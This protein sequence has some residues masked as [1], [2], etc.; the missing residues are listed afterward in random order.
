MRSVSGEGAFI[1]LPSTPSV[2]LN[3][4]RAMARFISSK[5]EWHLLTTEHHDPPPGG[6]H[7]ATSDL[8]TQAQLDH[9]HWALGFPC[10][11]IQPSAPAVRKGAF[12]VQKVTTYAAQ[13]AMPNR[14]PHNVTVV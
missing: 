10:C 4:P 2:W 5:G 14:V 3:T 1:D 12:A 7:L 6:S 11:P 13:L 8:S 9:P